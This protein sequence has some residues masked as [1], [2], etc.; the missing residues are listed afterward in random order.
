FYVVIAAVL[1]PLGIWLLLDRRTRARSVQ[2]NRI[3]PLAV[4][5][6]VIG[7]IYGI[8]GGSLLAPI[9]VGMGLSVLAVAP[10]TIT[11]TFVTSVVGVVAFAL[12]SLG[13]GGSIAPDWTLGIAMGLGGL[14]GG[15]CGARLQGRLPEAAIRRVL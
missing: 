10:A 1:L 13:Q 15:Y 8:G 4:I 12:L 7:G 5:V 14:A 11:V 3:L 9:L 6:G 2:R